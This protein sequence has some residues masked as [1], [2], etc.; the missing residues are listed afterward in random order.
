MARM[1]FVTLF[2]CFIVCLSVFKSLNNIL[3]NNIL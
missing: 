2:Y 1:T 3:Q